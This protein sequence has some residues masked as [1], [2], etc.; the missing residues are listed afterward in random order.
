M[1]QVLRLVITPASVC[2]RFDQGDSPGWLGH[3]PVLIMCAHFV[4]CLKWSKWSLVNV[5]FG[6]LVDGMY[7]CEVCR[8]DL[9]SFRRSITRPLRWSCVSDCHPSS[10]C[11][12]AVSERF[13]RG[14]A[15]GSSLRWATFNSTS[16]LFNQTAV[17]VVRL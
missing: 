16:L 15:S 10:C 3:Y 7:A 5:L 9:V 8:K 4:Q 14:V 13:E 2:E 12:T 1:G 6:V 11:R 17:N